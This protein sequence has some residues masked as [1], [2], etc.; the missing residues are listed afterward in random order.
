MKHKHVG[1]SRIYVQSAWWIQQS[2]KEGLI[3]AAAGAGVPHGVGGLEVTQGVVVAVRTL[4]V[5]FVKHNIAVVL[6]NQLAAF[7]ATV[8][9]GGPLHCVAIVPAPAALLDALCRR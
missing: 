7:R 9:V 6:H 1:G 4:R 2:A 5:I 8:G 3:A